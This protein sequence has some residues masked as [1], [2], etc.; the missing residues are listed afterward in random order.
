MRSVNSHRTT[1]INEWNWDKWQFGP[2]HTFSPSQPSW[3]HFWKSFSLLIYLV[4]LFCFCFFSLI[5]F[6]SSF[7]F[8]WEGRLKH[9][10]SFFLVWK[11]K[12]TL[13]SKSFSSYNMICIKNFLLAFYY[14]C[15][16]ISNQVSQ[17]DHFPFCVSVSKVNVFIFL[18]AL[19]F[20]LISLN[21]CICSTKLPSR[22][23]K[24]LSW[25]TEL[26]KQEN[27]WRDRGSAK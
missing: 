13:I 1:F 23:A 12:K 20:L 6:H 15:F 11:E 19:P 7:F 18:H 22:C 9:I 14:P 2:R 3:L 24:G 8:L 17:L 10:S 21:H 26:G 4:V 25:E 5:F 16:I 27:T